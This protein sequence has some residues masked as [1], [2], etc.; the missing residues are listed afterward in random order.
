MR[1]TKLW[2]C[3]NCGK[4]F[5]RKLKKRGESPK[6]CGVP[7]M[8]I[9]QRG[10]KGP[11]AH[12]QE[13]IDRVRTMAGEKLSATKIAAAIGKTRDAIIG[14]CFRHK[15]RLNGKPPGAPKGVKKPPRDGSVRRPAKHAL[16]PLQLEEEAIPDRPLLQIADLRLPIVQCPWI[17]G[18]PG[19]DMKG[20]CGEPTYAGTSYCRQHAARAYSTISMEDAA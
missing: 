8:A 4:E 5:T 17:Y 7:C 13:L 12:P 16:P 19:I 10:V 2:T 1:V 3:A 11:R 9:G 6:Y 15:I 14:I 18:R 20:Y